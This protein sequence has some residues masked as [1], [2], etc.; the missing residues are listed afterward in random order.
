MTPRKDDE[1]YRLMSGTTAGFENWKDRLVTEIFLETAD[2]DYVTARWLFL[3]GLHRMFFWNAAQAIEKYLKASLLLNGYSA[4]YKGHPIEKLFDHVMTF[5]GE[6]IPKQLEA[7]SSIKQFSEMNELW[8]DPTT[9]RFVVRVAAEGDPSNRYDYFG[10]EL[11]PGD[12]YKLDQTVFALRNLAVKLDAE[13]DPVNY[14]GMT[15]FDFI[16]KHPARQLRPCSAHLVDPSKAPPSV[17]SSACENNFP[18]APKSFEHHP[19]PLSIHVTVPSLEFL[20]KNEIENATMLR[21][22]VKKNIKLNNHEESRLLRPTGPTNH[23]RFDS[24]S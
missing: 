10:I 8:R 14:P 23:P 15:N 6:L 12:L 22:W 1:H 2:E 3:N 9:K 17:Y 4:I 24:P 16:K 7:P 19:V 11:E 13:L 20:W 5:A 21:R 18:F